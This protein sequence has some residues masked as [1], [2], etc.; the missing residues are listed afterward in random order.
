MD[1][2]VAD[3]QGCIRIPSGYTEDNSGYPYGKPV[4]DCLEYVLV[5]AEKLG[6]ATVNMDNQLGWCEYGSG[7]EMVAVLGH[8]DVVP[9]GDGWTVDPY[10]GEVKDG[11][12]FGRG[13]MDDKGPTMCALYALKAIAESGA[14]L[15]RRIRILFGLNE[16]TGSADMAYYKA[17]GGEIPVMGFT[18]DG[19][20]PIINGEKGLINEAYRCEFTQQGDLQVKSMWGGTV[21]NI[22]PNYAKAELVCADA[23]A[24]E[25]CAMRAEKITCTRTGDG[26]LVEAAGVNAHG[27]TPWEG[28]N[29]IGRLAQFLAKLPFSGAVQ[30][31]I[32]F[33]A[34]RIGMECD[35]KS[36][37]IAMEDQVSGILTMNLGVLR[38]DA[39]SMEVKLN[40]RYPV[41]RHFEECGPQTQAAFGAAGFVRSVAGHKA[42]LYMPPEHPLVAKLLKVYTDYTGDYVSAPKSIGGGT[43]AKM[44]PNVLAFGPIFPGDEV[45][46]HKPDEFMELNRLADNANIL[47]E[48][49][50]AL[51][52]D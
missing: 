19:E 41:T 34:A 45:R 3:L 25:I 26:V 50:Y 11:R 49:M 43:Y 47:A 16:E 40:Y 31:A 51:A 17:H 28:E 42:K 37:G 13:T 33:L 2:V 35:G 12:I 21:H 52:T 14:P 20:Y 24:A 38:A 29:A 23:L 9:E 27:G 44:L 10:G 1:A 6:F 15:Q 32:N 7:E 22:V 46:E 5:C 39:S 18:P 30:T 36:L 4:Q 48:A 8:L